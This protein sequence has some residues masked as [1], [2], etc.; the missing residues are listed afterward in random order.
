MFVLALLVPAGCHSDQPPLKSSA[1]K[2]G[3]APGHQD[4]RE[5]MVQQQIAARGVRDERV[6]AAMRSVPRHRFVPDSLD[7]QA[8]SDHPLP[9]GHNQTISQPY[10]VAVMTE[11]VAPAPDDRALDVGTGSGY[12][13][14]VFAEL[15]SQVYSIEIV[16]ELGK[17]ARQR[18]KALGYDNVTVRIGDGYQGWAEKAPFDVVVLA[19]APPEIPQPLIDQLAKGGR[20][21]LPVGSAGRQELLLIEKDEQGEITRRRISSV[22]FVPMTG[23]AQEDAGG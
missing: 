23:R 9:I 20:M 21:A 4:K 14:A 19:A 22:A 18:L 13:A 1:E 16:P 3:D 12:Q 17:Q 8:Y 10:V 2:P 5:A 6:L 11:L 7:R 15:V